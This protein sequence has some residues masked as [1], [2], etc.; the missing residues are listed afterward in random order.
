MTETEAARLLA[1]IAAA[2]Q[3]EEPFDPERD[4]TATMLAERMGVTATGA[5]YMLQ[6]EVMAGKL[7]RRTARR[8]GQS[9][10]V[11]YR[12]VNP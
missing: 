11:A 4:I 3:A 1:E 12:R 5:R 10:V 9:P 7:T 8:P 6:R 2:Y